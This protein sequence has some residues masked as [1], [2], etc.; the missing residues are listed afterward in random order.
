MKNKFFDLFVLGIL[1]I[2][3]SFGQSINN[4]VSKKGT[5]AATFLSIGQGTRA[6]GM[7]RAYVAL[8]DDPSVLESGWY[9]KSKWSGIYR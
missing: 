3:S 8:A 6:T 2:T 5:T 4:D 9:H 7:G 1:F